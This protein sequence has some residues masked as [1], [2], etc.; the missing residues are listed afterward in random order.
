MCSGRV[1]P[2]MIIES[3]I[4][5]A[6]GVFVGACK[7]G[8]CHYTSGNLHAEGKMELTKRVLRMA[9]I[10]SARLRMRMMSSAEGNKFVEFASEF[11]VDITELGPLG[12]P[13]GIDKNDLSIKL[14]AAAKALGGRKIRWVTGKIVEFTEKGNLYGEKFTAHEIGRL[15][16]EIAMDEFRLREILERLKAK[17]HSVKELASRMDTA[18][19]ILVRQMA[20]LKKMGFAEI[21]SVEGNTPMWELSG[22]GETAYE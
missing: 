6:D 13:E 14:Q 16:D 5:G 7:R 19:K 1:D 20:D 15:F 21:H 3:F 9:G 8:E 12:K 18:P 17:P 22:N 11:Q 2:V 10:D 4:A